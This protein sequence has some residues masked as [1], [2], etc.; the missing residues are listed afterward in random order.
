MTKRI[1]AYLLPY[2]LAFFVYILNYTIIISEVIKMVGIINERLYVALGSIE[3]MHKCGT[4]MLWISKKDAICL[5]CTMEEMGATKLTQAL[6]Q[7][8]FRFKR[9]E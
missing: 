8:Q 4:V 1:V 7:G 5:K 9:D 2:A 3:M 6:N